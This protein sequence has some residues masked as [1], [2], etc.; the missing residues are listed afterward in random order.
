WTLH[1]SHAPR[2]GPRVT[3]DLPCVGAALPTLGKVHARYPHVCSPAVEHPSRSGGVS[4]LAVPRRSRGRLW[5]LLLRRLRWV[6]SRRGLA[7]TEVSAAGPSW[8]THRLRA[9]SWSAHR[10]RASSRLRLRSLARRL[11][12]RDGR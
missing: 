9:S 10:L 11:R 6:L 1:C 5:G 12:R 3:T 4:V 7:G 8:S 2:G